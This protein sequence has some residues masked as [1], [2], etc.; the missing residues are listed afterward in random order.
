MAD[1]YEQYREMREELI[2]MRTDE[3]IEVYDK[4][5]CGNLDDYLL[6][7][8][9]EHKLTNIRKAVAEGKKGA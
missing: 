8:I 3:L 2:W 4:L 9:F 1:N 6:E 7:N 5:S